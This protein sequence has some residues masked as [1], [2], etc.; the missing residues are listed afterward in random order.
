MNPAFWL[1]IV[2]G[3]ALPM[4]VRYVRFRSA[5]TDSEHVSPAWLRSN[6]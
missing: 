3:L 4:L 5:L 6:R 1:G 2:A